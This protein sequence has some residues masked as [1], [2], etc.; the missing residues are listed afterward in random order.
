MNNKCI[1]TNLQH[2]VR[3]YLEY[4]WQ[5]SNESDHDAEQ[6]ILSQLTGNLK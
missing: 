4:F 3:E 5:E 2:Q 1:N 6:L